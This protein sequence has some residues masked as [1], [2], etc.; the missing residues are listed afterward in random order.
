MGW[1]AAQGARH[2]SVLGGNIQIWLWLWSCEHCPWGC[3]LRTVNSLHL[4]SFVELELA[5]PGHSWARER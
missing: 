5:E 1:E 3:G 4:R 2:W